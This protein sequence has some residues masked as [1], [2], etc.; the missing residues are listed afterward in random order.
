M[1][2]AS[3]KKKY[4]DRLSDE[5]D[6]ISGLL[7][8]LPRHLLLSQRFSYEFSNWLPLYWAGFKQTTRYTY[9]IEE[10]SDLGKVWENIRYGTKRKINLAEKQGIRV[11][12]DLGLEKLLDLNRMTY[13]KQGLTAPYSREY[14]RRL[15]EACRKNNASKMFFAIDGEGRIH[16]AAYIVYDRKAAYY[17]LGGGDPAINQ[18]GGHFLTL[19]E[20]IKFASG[21]SQTFDFEGSMHRNI[22]PVFRGFGGVQ[23][24]YMEI[25]R[26]SLPVE[27]AYDAL[28]NV[29]NNGGL[30]AK[31]CAKLLH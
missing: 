13:Q 17:L 23:K 26:G 27:I 14:V 24:P 10:L 28:R 15:D 19:W 21:V 31:I 1:L 2:A 29:W 16:A 6:L 11:V 18:Y 5:I 9:V 22:E 25:T 8:H 7:E 20:A 3:G 4:S 30:P 12:T